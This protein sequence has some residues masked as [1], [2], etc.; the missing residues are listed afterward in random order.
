MW[1]ERILAEQ[2]IP[3]EVLTPEAYVDAYHVAMEA[4]YAD[5]PLMR[6]AQLRTRMNNI[7]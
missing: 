5:L 4:L 6:G 3:P 2:E 7:E 1:A